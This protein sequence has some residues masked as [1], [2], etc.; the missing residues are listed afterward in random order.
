MEFLKFDF[1]ALTALFKAVT[2]AFMT[3]FRKLGFDAEDY[4]G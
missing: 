3:L 1:D 2:D 4:L